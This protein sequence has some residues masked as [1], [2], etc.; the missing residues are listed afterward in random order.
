QSKARPGMS[1]ESDNLT[2]DACGASMKADAL[3]CDACGADVK[4]AA[5]SGDMAS[6]PIPSLEK[7][8]SAAGASPNTVTFSIAPG[9]ITIHPDAATTV[10]DAL[11]NRG[12]MSFDQMVQCPHCGKPRGRT[13][14]DGA[15][16]PNCGKV[17]PSPPFDPWALKSDRYPPFVKIDSVI[18]P[19][20]D[21][22]QILADGDASAEFT[23]PWGILRVRQLATIADSINGND[24]IYPRD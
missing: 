1:T 23:D 24:R 9:A 10:E 17:V 18:V 8:D 13:M 5:G 22:V 12:P 21:E 4:K 2:C 19:K 15:A 20:D 3:K 11:Q 14:V 16:C 7:T 6:T